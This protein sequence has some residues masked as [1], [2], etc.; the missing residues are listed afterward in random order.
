M[1]TTIAA[2]S[3]DILLELPKY[4]NRSYSEYAGYQ[5]CSITKVEDSP[6]RPKSHYKLTIRVLDKSAPFRLVRHETVSGP[7]YSQKREHYAVGPFKI[8][9]EG[10]VIHE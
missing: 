5:N 2:E 3:S 1:L 6:A 7:H 4:V 8:G 10:G 9:E